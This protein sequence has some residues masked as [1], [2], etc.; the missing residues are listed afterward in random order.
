MGEGHRTKYA[1][2]EASVANVLNR[3]AALCAIADFTRH[4][5]CL[6]NG[7]GA[8]FRIACPPVGS[9]GIQDVLQLGCILNYKRFL[10]ILVTLRLH[11]D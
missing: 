4:F 5:F 8:Y 1:P 10:L 6:K 3:L 2:A 11:S 9:R 7:Q